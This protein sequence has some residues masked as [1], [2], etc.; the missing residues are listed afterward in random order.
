MMIPSCKIPAKRLPSN[1][2]VIRTYPVIRIGSWCAPP[3]TPRET[4]VGPGK[5]SCVKESCWEVWSSGGN[6]WLRLE[7]CYFVGPLQGSLSCLRIRQLLGDVWEGSS[8][9]SIETKL[10]VMESTQ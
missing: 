6:C 5:V 4:P 1:S 8:G 3:P 9:L 2:T 7:N 10:K